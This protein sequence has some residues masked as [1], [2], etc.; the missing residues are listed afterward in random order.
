MGLIS[1][2]LRNLTM[3]YGDSYMHSELQDAMRGVTT[4]LGDWS[5]SCQSF[6]L[7]IHFKNMKGS[8]VQ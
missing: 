5:A 6:R 4:S 1:G 8:L 3:E 2:G 7:P